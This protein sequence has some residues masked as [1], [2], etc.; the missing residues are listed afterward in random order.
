ML[1]PISA[2]LT[3]KQLL[4]IITYKLIKQILKAKSQLN[5]VYQIKKEDTLSFYKEM[6][7]RLYH[8]IKKWKTDYIIL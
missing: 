6:E 8:S 1:T 3:I 4:H 2:F 5:A 7:D